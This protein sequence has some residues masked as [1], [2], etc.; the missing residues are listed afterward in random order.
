MI[1]KTQATK[2]KIDMWNYIKLNNFCGQ[3]TIN[4][5]KR[6]PTEEEKN[7]CRSYVQ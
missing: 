7:I 6:Q 1:P 3:K 4:K 2:V 5:V